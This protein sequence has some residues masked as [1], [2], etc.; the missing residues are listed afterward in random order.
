MD[1]RSDASDTLRSLLSATANRGALP[2]LD[3]DEPSHA[4]EWH[5]D[6]GVPDP[7]LFPIDDLARIGERVLREDA[8]AAW[9]SG[10]APRTGVSLSTARRER[11]VSLAAK[12]GFMILEDDVY[13]GLRYEG[14]SRPTLSSL[15]ERGLVLR[16]Q[17]MSKTLA[18]A[19]RL[20]WVTGDADAIDRHCA[21]ALRV[22][23]PEGGLFLWC[24]LDPAFD[25]RAVLWRP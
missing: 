18:P 23:K 5:F 19:L 25:G 20:G 6:A 8:E 2:N 12:W 9:P 24:E 1:S 17:S 3:F 13:A 16:I 11:L 4:I 15:D 14:E 21:G 10:R 7:A 22:A